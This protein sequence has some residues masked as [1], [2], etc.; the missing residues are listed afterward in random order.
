MTKDGGG[1]WV[2]GGGY[3][4]ICCPMA[5]QPNTEGVCRFENSGNWGMISEIPRP[6]RGMY[7]LSFLP[8][9]HLFT[10][11]PASWLRY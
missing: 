4:H 8:Q 9:D 5:R 2:L 7:S 6:V 1:G 11:A 10:D 3:L